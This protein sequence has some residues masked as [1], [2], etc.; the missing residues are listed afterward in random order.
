MFRTTNQC[1]AVLVAAAVG[2]AVVVACVY[3]L[4]TLIGWALTKI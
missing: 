4:L 1:L 2:S 3:G